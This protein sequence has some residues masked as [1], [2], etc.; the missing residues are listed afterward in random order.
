MVG[1]G[2]FGTFR[3]KKKVEKS[4]KKTKIMAF[5][6][7]SSR[8][9]R[10]C[11]NKFSRCLSL[12]SQH[13]VREIFITEKNKTITIEGVSKDS[14]RKQNTIN[15]EILRS[16]SCGAKENCHAL[17]R[18]SQVNEVK[19]TDILILEQF[20]DSKGK[21]IP[22]DITGL[23]ERQHYRVEKLIGMAQKAGLMGSKDK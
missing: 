16:K 6:N 13:Y 4:K 11:N 15:P 18:F 21:T 10:P 14:K 23:C 8:I 5:I 3:K 20:V 22:R 17:C 2:S 12:S 19:H 9:V 7:L 1:F